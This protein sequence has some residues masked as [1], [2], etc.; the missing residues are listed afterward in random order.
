MAENKVFITP[1]TDDWALTDVER[2]TVER[3]TMPP[4]YTTDWYIISIANGELT[5]LH[6]DEIAALYK[7]AFGGDGDAD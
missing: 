7:F 5:R 1:D 3:V 6:K 4:P 2:A